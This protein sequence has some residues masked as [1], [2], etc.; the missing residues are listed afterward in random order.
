M[1]CYIN[2]KLELE[3]TETLELNTGKTNASLI[4]LN[5]GQH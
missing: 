4:L 1:L 5:L 3:L 2:Y